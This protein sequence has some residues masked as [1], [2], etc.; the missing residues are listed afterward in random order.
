MR[1][2]RLGQHVWAI[3]RAKVGR[4]RALRPD[5][6]C[7]RAVA[8]LG[9]AAVYHRDDDECGADWDLPGLNTVRLATARRRRRS[10]FIVL[11]SI[12]S[13]H[14]KRDLSREGQQQCGLFLDTP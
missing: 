14:F 3:P 10:R 6:D 13:R 5:E 9:V 11:D 8:A 2:K 1:A 7:D 4:R 12:A